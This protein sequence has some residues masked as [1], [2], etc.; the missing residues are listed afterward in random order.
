M[1][2]ERGYSLAELMVV[3]AIIGIFSLVTVP[4]F[5]KYQQSSQIRASTRQMNADFRAARQRAITRN[6]PVAVSF[7]V[8]ATPGGGFRK[9]QYALFDRVVDTSTD[10]DTIT[11]VRIGVWKNMLDPV[12]FLD[13]DFASDAATDDALDDVIFLGN[14][15]IANMPVGA[16]ET[17]DVEF[18]TDSKVP[19]NHVKDTFN[20][21]GFFQSVLSTD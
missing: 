8:G 18:K 7:A 2:S 13:S 5:M 20:A 9:G 10:P 12:Y 14:G 4:A 21:S 19:N 3:V 16:G 11:W 15:T 17:P 1:T 6:N